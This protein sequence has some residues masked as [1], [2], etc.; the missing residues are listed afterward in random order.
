MLSG[1]PKATGLEKEAD[2]SNTYNILMNTS[3]TNCAAIKTDTPAPCVKSQA[4][5]YR[6]KFGLSVTDNNYP[7]QSKSDSCCTNEAAQQPVHT[8]GIISHCDSRAGLMKCLRS[9]TQSSVHPSDEVQSQPQTRDSPSIET[10]AMMPLATKQ[11]DTEVASTPAEENWMPSSLPE[12]SQPQPDEA[13]DLPAAERDTARPHSR[14]GE[15]LECHTLVKGLRSYDALSP[16]TSPHPRPAPSLCSKWKKER[17]VDLREGTTPG[18][19]TS[20]EETRTMKIPVRSGI[21]AKRALV[22][23]A[24]PSSSTGIPRVRSKTEPLTG[25]PTN[26]NPPTPTRLS[27]PRSISMRSSPITKPAVVQAEVRRSNSTRER[28]VEAPGKPTLTRRTSDRSFPEKGSGGMQPVFIRGAPLR[29]SKRLAPNSDT[30]APAQPHTTQ[31]PSSATAKTIRTAVI[32][33]ARNKTAKT[34]STSTSP[35]S[36]KIPTSSRIPG[37]KMPRATAAQPLWR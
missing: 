4:S 34:T 15:T 14:V 3:T 20:K 25:A 17:E 37:P 32:S 28:N 19:P 30:Q 18:S 16:P 8:S 11:T 9:K 27:A 10:S 21:G 29:V 13:S 22:S 5:A 7:L 24:G 26:I 2:F 31:S 33:A 36:S 6:N 1:R 35:V 12:F 23:R